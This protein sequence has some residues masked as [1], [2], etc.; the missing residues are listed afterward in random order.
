MKKSLTE[1]H[2]LIDL[3]E[4]F[5]E[6][7][8]PKVING[9]P[10]FTT[11]AMEKQYSCLKS[12]AAGFRNIEICAWDFSKHAIYKDSTM[13]TKIETILKADSLKELVND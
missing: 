11:A 1:Y 9:L 12:R 2:S 13:S 10:D 4:E 8:K 7:I 5:R 3:F 6:Y